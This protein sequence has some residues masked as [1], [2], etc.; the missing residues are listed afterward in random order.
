MG[1][2]GGEGGLGEE[3]VVVEGFGVLVVDL[4]VVFGGEVWWLFYVEQDDEILLLIEKLIN[5]LLS[6]INH[7]RPRMP[8]QP[9][10]HLLTLN[11]IFPLILPNNR[12]LVK[13]PV[14]GQG[15]FILAEECF[16]AFLV[17]LEVVVFLFG[18]GG[19]DEFFVGGGRLFVS[20]VD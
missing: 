20:K 18:F 1:A 2:F 15:F 9:L 8:L 10:Q 6:N 16:G 13:A 4:A 12:W 19:E 3:E 7:N 5:T 11:L 14:D 17:R